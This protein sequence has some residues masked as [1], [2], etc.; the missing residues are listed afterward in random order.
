LSDDFTPL[1]NFLVRQVWTEEFSDVFHVFQVN[2]QNRKSGNDRCFQVVY[3]IGRS[4]SEDFLQNRLFRIG[5]YT[6]ESEILIF[7][8]TGFQICYR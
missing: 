8:F 3:R 2:L 6:S 4:E 1:L 5:K 7:M